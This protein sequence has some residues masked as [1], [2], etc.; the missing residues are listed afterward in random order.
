MTDTSSKNLNRIA[1]RAMARMD[2]LGDDAIQAMRSTPRALAMQAENAA[3]RRAAAKRADAKQAKARA[4]SIAAN[5]FAVGQTVRSAR[6]MGADFMVAV[7]TAVEGS[8]ITLDNGRKF[9]ASAFVAA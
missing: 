3:K 1:D 8:T 4:A 6:L 2:A 9:A 5:T 7:V